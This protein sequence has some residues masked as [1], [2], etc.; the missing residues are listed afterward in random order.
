MP[1]LCRLPR[2]LRQACPVLFRQTCLIL[3]CGPRHVQFY[4]A[5]LAWSSSHF[6]SLHF[7]R[8]PS[9]AHLLKSGASKVSL[10]V[11]PGMLRLRPLF[12]QKTLYNL[13]SCF[14]RCTRMPN[15]GKWA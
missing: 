7:D 15:S 9:F 14:T 13:K 10:V 8:H 5:T 6:S 12:S 1:P 2:T 11:L 3:V 4:F